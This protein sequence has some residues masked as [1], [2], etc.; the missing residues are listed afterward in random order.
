[1]VKSA[2]VRE[3]S[4]MR[5]SLCICNRKCKLFKKELRLVFTIL[6]FVDLSVVYVYA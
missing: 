4:N 1:M 6:L 2:C 3:N 5:W